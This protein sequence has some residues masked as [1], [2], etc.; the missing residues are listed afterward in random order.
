[1]SRA[2][3]IAEA[4]KSRLEA[5]RTAAGYATDVGTTVYRGRRQLNEE[6]ACTLFEGEEDASGAA[7][8]EPY[9]VT[10]IIHFTAEGAVACD[11]L[12]PDLAGHDLVADMQRALFTG[13]STLGGLLAGPLT[14]T[15]RVIQPR[16]D[17]QS[18]VTVQIKLD[19]IYTMTPAT[20]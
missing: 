6:N 12:N 4:L 18:I 10:A 13:D 19:A 20:P 5:I 3:D 16:Q 15:G 17:G 1:M 2:N 14:Y 11:P 7:K 8:K 9:T